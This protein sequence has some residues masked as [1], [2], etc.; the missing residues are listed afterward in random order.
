MQ[1]GLARVLG[2]TF[3][4]KL[5]ILAVIFLGY[6]SFPFQAGNYLANFHDPSQEPPTL[7]S[8]YQT[9]DAQHYLYLAAHGYH[10]GEPSNAFFPL[11]PLLIRFFS[12]PTGLAP[13]ITGLF[14]SLLFALLASAFL[15]LLVR[16]LWNEETAFRACLWCLAF[17]TA[18]FSGLIYTESLFLFLALAFFYFFHRRNRLPAVFCA[19][20]LSLS[21]PT[22][23]LIAFALIP[24][25]KKGMEVSQDSRAGRMWTPLA[26]VS[27]LG[28]YLLLMKLW[29][30]DY[31]SG[32]FAQHYFVSHNQFSNFLNPWSWFMENFIRNPYTW[33]GPQTS[34]LN[35]A[36]F[37]GVLAALPSLYRHVGKGFFLY[38]LVL[39]VVPALLSDLMSYIRYV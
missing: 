18:F 14:L 7:L 27:G 1:K 39:G 15:Y 12:I 4:V 31:F 34:F 25:G 26:F 22:G 37:V 16:E 23:I 17:P 3:L 30:G 24:W 19:F 32:F 33:N 20:L 5:S 6:R 8:A 10:A 28:L 2:I 36:L 11:L 21:R 13:W 38:T 35:R 29:T 9:W